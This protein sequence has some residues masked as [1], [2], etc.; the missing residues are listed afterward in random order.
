MGHSKHELTQKIMLYSL[1]QVVILLPY[2]PYLIMATSLQ[3]PLSFVPEVTVVETFDC[4]QLF[5]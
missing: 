1:K 3:R 4:C 2:L 5:Y